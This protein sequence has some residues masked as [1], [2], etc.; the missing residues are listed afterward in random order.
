[1]SQEQE[2]QDQDQERLSSV[3]LSEK[4]D[5]II[6]ETDIESQIETYINLS[7]KDKETIKKYS[8]NQGLLKSILKTQP[9]IEEN[10]MLEKQ[11]ILYCLWILLLIVCLP[12]IICDLYFAYNDDTCVNKYPSDINVNLKQYFIISALSTVVIININMILMNYFIKIEF[13]PNICFIILT[14]IFTCLLG[15]FCAVWNILGAFIFWGSIYHGG[16]CS[17]LVSTYVF[18]SLIVKF[19]LTIYAY[20]KIRDLL[21]EP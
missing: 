13:N 4:S 6:S 15:S 21:K 1:M 17:K 19:C 8:Q 18:V 11:I 16:H 2:D 9:S 5:S 12:M 14:Y 3:I 7:E 20:K 10:N